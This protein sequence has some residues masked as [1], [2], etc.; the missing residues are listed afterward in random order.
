MRQRR[1]QSHRGSSTPEIEGGRDGEGAV[2]S[3]ALPFA[4][5]KINRAPGAARAGLRRGGSSPDR[6]QPERWR[7][8]CALVLTWGGALGYLLANS[9]KEE[10]A[11]SFWPSRCRDMASLSKLSGALAL[12]P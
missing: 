8:A 2:S 4:L 10:Q 11:A 3:C 7:S 6:Q 5:L 12:R 1:P 9:L